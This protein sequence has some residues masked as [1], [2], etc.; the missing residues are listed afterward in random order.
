MLD[1]ESPSNMLYHEVTATA[2]WPLFLARILVAVG[3]RVAR[4]CSLQFLY[5]VAFRQWWTR[6]SWDS[7]ESTVP[8][9]LGVS[10]LTSPNVYRQ[11]YLLLRDSR[12]ATEAVRHEL[13]RL[14]ARDSRRVSNLRMSTAIV[15]VADEL[16]RC[17]STTPASKFLPV[18][19]CLLPFPF[20]SICRRKLLIIV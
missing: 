1:C 9:L 12:S 16:F 2:S 20:C 18:A 5:H 13:D 15:I 11:S 10:T 8:S 7:G 6:P 14:F 3:N 4:T 19:G 17:L